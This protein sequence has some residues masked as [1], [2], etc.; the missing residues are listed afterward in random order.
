MEEVEEKL[1]RILLR[2][3]RSRAKI[4]RKRRPGRN[5]GGRRFL[6]DTVEAFAPPRIGIAFKTHKEGCGHIGVLQIYQPL[7]SFNVH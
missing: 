6:T 5:D 2:S 3:L 7:T 1:E 4:R